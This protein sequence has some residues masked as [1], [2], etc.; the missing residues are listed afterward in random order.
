MRRLIVLTLAATSLGSSFVAS[1]TGLGVT[2]PPVAARKA[3]IARCDSNGITLAYTTSAG[4]VTSVTV[5]GIADPGCEGAE[6]SVTLTNAAGNSI[7]S[8][9]PQTVA[10]DGDAVDNSVT[11]AVSPN[12]A[13]EQVSGYQVSVVGP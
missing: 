5:N 12:P 6:M 2:S 11:V 10:T 1:A 4:N 8:G 3:A 13:A 7:A 9:G